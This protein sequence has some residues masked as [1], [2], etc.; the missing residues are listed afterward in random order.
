M[1]DINALNPEL[2]KNCSTWSVLFFTDASFPYLSLRI[3]PFAMDYAQIGHE[4]A[5]DTY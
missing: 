2:Q 1:S 5:I 3:T 4:M